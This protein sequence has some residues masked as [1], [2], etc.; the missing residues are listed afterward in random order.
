MKLSYVLSKEFIELV[1][2]NITAPK[3]TIIRMAERRYIYANPKADEITVFESDVDR[4]IDIINNTE[5]SFDRYASVYTWINNNMS[6]V[7]SKINDMKSLWAEYRAFIT[8]RGIEWLWAVTG[9]YNANCAVE[10]EF[11]TLVAEV[12]GL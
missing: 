1:R 4:A 7:K 8:A 5:S 2:L 10:K 9:V 3:A 12:A 11:G 6:V